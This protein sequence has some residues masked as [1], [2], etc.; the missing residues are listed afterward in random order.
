QAR[1]AW[2]EED[3]QPPGQSVSRAR[4]IFNAAEEAKPFD[5]ADFDFAM[6]DEEPADALPE[7]SVSSIAESSPVQPSP[8]ASASRTRVLGMTGT[9]LA[10]VSA[11]AIALLCIL[12]VFALLLLNPTFLLP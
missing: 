10:I 8:A 2:Q 5:P 11:L 12:V 3:T 4:A 7:A 6:L 9:Q 1:P